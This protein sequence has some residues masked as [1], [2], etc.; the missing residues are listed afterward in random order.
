VPTNE[1]PERVEG[2]ET[3]RVRARQWIEE[4]LERRRP[5]A[6]ALDR[7]AEQRLQA[8]L[9]DDGFSG[10][11]FPTRFGGAG[12]TLDHQKVFFD[13]AADFVT[14]SIYGVS[15]GMLAP[16][17]FECGS[18][19]L[20]QRHLPPM[21]R[22]D[23]EFLQLLTEPSSGSDMA[24]ALTRADR[25]GDSWVVNGSKMWSSFAMRATHGL[26]LART[27]WEVPKHRGLSMFVMPLGDHPGVTI[28]PI[29]NV[30]GE[31]DF[32]SEFF[33]SVVIPAQNLLGEQDEGWGVA[34]RLLMH[35][36]N[37][38][39]GIGYG[40]GYLNYGDS[41]AGAR[42]N[43]TRR[44]AQ[45]LATAARRHAKGDPAVRQLIGRG[46]VD[47]VA[48]ELAAQRV[49]KGQRTGALTGQWGSLL[50]LGE[51][52]NTPA[53]AELTMAISGADGVIWTDEQA[54]G[55]EGLAWLFSRAISISGG[56]N[57]MQRNIISERLLGMPREHDPS[58][59]E[60]FSEIQRRRTGKPARG[61][62]R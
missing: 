21:L 12:L 49:M 18:E 5:E 9:F 51:G 60:P 28:E 48:Q 1:E 55:T 57:E 59:T 52:I 2:V 45:F 24:G 14:P 15:I 43:P 44:E 41:G 23:E 35:E 31:S 4:N 16:T 36:R 6:P 54:G 56:S 47:L 61:T 58:R 33:D 17:I 26:L 50:K 32:C 27:N 11:A 13:E 62:T 10:F 40:Y 29:K 34:Q 7:A 30:L 39:A 25:D 19:V 37:A 38:A 20:K 42:G 22:G 46:Y 3:F 8:K 53:L